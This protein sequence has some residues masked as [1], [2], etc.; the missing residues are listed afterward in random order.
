MVRPGLKTKILTLSLACVAEYL[1]NSERTEYGAEFIFGV[2][3]PAVDDILSMMTD[4]DY[5]D[6]M[7]LARTITRDIKAKLSSLWIYISQQS[8]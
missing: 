4:E 6:L 5:H 8:G 7:L 2:V 3:R 1:K